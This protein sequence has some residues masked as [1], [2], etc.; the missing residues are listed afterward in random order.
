MRLVC[1]FGLLMALPAIAFA[2]AGE[3]VEEH[4]QIEAFLGVPDPVSVLFWA[5]AL[6]S[7]VIILSLALRLT[8]KQK[9]AAYIAIAAPIVFGT[10]YLAG[11]TVALNLTSETGG[12][13]HWHAD[14]EVWICGER[15]ELV[16]PEWWE[17]RVGEADLHE[18]N[19]NRIHIEGVFAK[20]SQ[21]SLSK[22]FEAVGG[23]LT[24][25]AIAFPTAKGLIGRIN[26]DE[27]GGKAGKLMVFVNGKVLENYTGYIIAPYSNVPPGDRI[28]F[29]FTEKAAPNTGQGEVP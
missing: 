23:K 15:I 3:P 27:C 25:E 10:L 22:Y 26:G 29:V 21:A 13:V 7:I 8:E 1:L 24:P 12:P 20:K 14:Y 6:F 16:E 5:T 19:D 2:H 18:H 17:N 4:S 9:K 11:V 28:K